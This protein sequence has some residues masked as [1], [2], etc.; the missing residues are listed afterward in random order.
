MVFSDYTK[1]RILFYRARG[2]RS[3]TIANK[4]QDEGIVVSRRGVSDFLLRVNQTCST[5]RRPG[6]GRPSKQTD[7]VR[8]TVE[9]TMRADDETTVK[10]LHER[11]TSQGTSL[12]KSTVLRC[13]QS[14]GWTVRGSA[15]C[16]MIR[17]VNK[18]KRLE[19]ATK[20]LPEAG[21][22]FLNVIFTDE[23]SIQME[24]HR[25]FCCRKKGEAPKN[26]PRYMYILSHVRIHVHVQCSTCKACLH[27][28]ACFSFFI[29]LSIQ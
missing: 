5:T 23:T 19:W 4:L 6:S 25:R 3:P 20:F 24:S 9:R 2:Y 7:Q 8:E 1:R 16:Q 26:K 28:H 13:R 12:S 18:T 22:G 14:L 29:E 27:I 21:A 11:L 17:E 15:Y 10:E